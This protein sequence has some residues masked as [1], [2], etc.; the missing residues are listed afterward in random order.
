M[1]SVP[2]LNPWSS[3]APARQGAVPFG[4]ACPRQNPAGDSVSFAPGGRPV[5]DPNVSL[6]AF[7]RAIAEKVQSRTPANASAVLA[8]L[9]QTLDVFLQNQAIRGA[10]AK[11][12][13]LLQ[14]IQKVVGP[15]AQGNLA[16]AQ[17]NFTVGD[18][19]GNAR[20]VMAYIDAAEKAG[21]DTVVFPEQ[22][23]TGWPLGDLVA[24]YPQL[25]EDQLKVLHALAAK[26]QKTRVMLGFVEP[27]TPDF[28]QLPAQGRRFFNSLAILGNGQIEGIV[29]KSALP[30]YQEFYEGRQLEPSPS[31]G[32]HPPETLC[33]PTWGQGGVKPEGALSQIHGIRYA[34][35][36][37]EDIWADGALTGNALYQQNPMESLMRLKPE[38]L[39]NVS[40]SP[41]RAHKEGRKH[42]MLKATAAKWQVPLVYVNAVGGNDDLVY[43][44]ASRVYGTDGKLVARAKSFEEQFLIVNPR[45]GQGVVFPLPNGK[46]LP[47][48]VNKTSQFQAEDKGDLAR[49]Y[50]S[51]RLAL[52]DYWRKNGYQKAVLGVSGGIDSAVAAALAVDALGVKN[53]LGVFMPSRG[54]TQDESRRDA[55]ALCRNLGIPL[56]NLPIGG[57]LDAVE[58]VLNPAFEQISKIWGPP[59]CNP[60]THQN[61]QARIRSLFLRAIT[62]QFGKVLMIG[63]SD[64]SESVIGNGT[65]AGDLS[66]DYAVLKDI[67]KLKLNALARWINRQP[68]T[69][70]WIPRHIIT[71]PPTAELDLKAGGEAVLSDDERYGSTFLLRDEATHKLLRGTSLAQM[72]E[73]NFQAQ[74]AEG[75]SEEGKAL[76]LERFFYHLAKNGIFKW[77]HLAKGPI[78]DEKGLTSGEL[79]IP[80]VAGWNVPWGGVQ[81]HEIQQA[82]DVESPFST[83]T[84]PERVTK[85]LQE[86]GILPA[87][88]QE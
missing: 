61:N 54:I 24:F 84:F 49:T 27:R 64:K 11:K 40:A 50:Q 62:N 55:E 2:L 51:A 44:G 38:V 82:L 74:Q 76:G 31:V 66:S 88:P 3:I 71:K 68:Q 21:V 28:N 70:G 23:L 22:P 45:Q 4:A 79:Q 59:A 85:R 39:I 41:S 35:S 87:P 57:V 26:T 14:Q 36:I 53:V 37:C 86:L 47:P 72:L 32:M 48:A 77:G 43:D 58:Q 10:G 12:Q 18:L 75:L 33:S 19:L 67:S 13:F 56:M 69:Q 52:K 46:A 65:V 73:Q 6:T 80:I 81:A 42:G 7:K 25:V 1:F 34:A 17:I 78:L 15:R 5:V 30:T 63:T 20:K 16:I 60:Q 9:T 29:R 83:Q 8:D